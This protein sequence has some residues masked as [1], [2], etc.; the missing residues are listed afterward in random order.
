MKWSN[1]MLQLST[2]S[3]AGLIKK[4]RVILQHLIPVVGSSLRV[5]WLLYSTRSVFPALI[6]EPGQE[7]SRRLTRSELDTTHKLYTR[8]GVCMLTAHCSPVYEWPAN[9]GPSI[10]EPTLQGKRV[11]RNECHC[12]KGRS[13]KGEA[14][15]TLPCHS[16]CLEKLQGNIIIINTLLKLYSVDLPP[17]WDKCTYSAGGIGQPSFSDMLMN[18]KHI[19]KC[20]F[21]IVGT[22][23]IWLQHETT[24]VSAG[25]LLAFGCNV[26]LPTCPQLPHLHLLPAWCLTIWSRSSLAV[27]YHGCAGL[28]YWLVQHKATAM[29]GW[30]CCSNTFLSKKPPSLSSSPSSLHHPSP[31]HHRH[32][33]LS[34]LTALFWT[35]SIV[36]NLLWPLPF[37]KTTCFKLIL[38]L[39]II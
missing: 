16:A 7:V 36:Y 11:A 32:C 22:I 5:L 6:S 12:M 8:R 30:L 23:I 35:L 21:F 20:T 37:V 34:H 4:S 39:G 26:S 13:V 9:T 25:L 19:C 29:T 31:F 2:Q 27:L 18:T 28:L 15:G 1:L 38:N 14:G 10:H 17:Q 33:S 3:V 24:T